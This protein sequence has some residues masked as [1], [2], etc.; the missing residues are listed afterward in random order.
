MRWTDDYKVPTAEYEG[1]C[2]GGV[3]IV[4]PHCRKIFDDLSKRGEPSFCPECKK[5]VL[6]PSWASW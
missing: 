3:T 4:C 1:D 5:E 2:K 6:Y